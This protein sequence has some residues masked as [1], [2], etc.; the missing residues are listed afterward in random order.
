MVMPLSGAKVDMGSI[1]EPYRGTQTIDSVEAEWMHRYRI[2][3]TSAGKSE[4]K[5]KCDILHN[6]ECRL[7]QLLG[8][9]GIADL[10]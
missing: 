10:N 4:M 9:N 2:D 7:K 3:L 8:K 6:R 5:K 1:Y